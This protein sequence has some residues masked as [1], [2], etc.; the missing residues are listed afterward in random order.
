MAFFTKNKYPVTRP[1]NMVALPDWFQKI[2]VQSK[3][4]LYVLA[5]GLRLW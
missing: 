2:T 3:F 5:G 1:L 4:L